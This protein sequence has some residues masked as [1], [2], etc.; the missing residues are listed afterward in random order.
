MTNTLQRRGEVDLGN[1]WENFCD[2]ITSTDNRIY[3]G[4][5]GVLM[6]P[7]ILSAATCFLI[8][9]LVAPPVDMEGIREP[10]IGALLDGNN[11]LTAAVIPTSAAIGLHFYPIWDAAS[12]DEW[13]YNG[14]P[15]QFIILHFLIGVWCYLGRLWELSYRLGMRP[16]ISVAFSA[17]AGAATAIF[18]IYP[19]G[20]GSFSEGMPLGISGTFHFMLGFQATHNILMNPLHMLGVTG[21]F[22]G[23]LLASLHGSLVTSSLVRETTLDE[24]INAG[25][26]FG[27]QET[28]YNL[29]AGHQ[30][31]LGRLLIP[32]LGVE[33]S[34]SLH[35][36]IV[37][38]P[39]VG[40]WCATLAI[41]VMAF[42]L[43]GFNFNQSILDSY[44]HP[45]PTDADILNRANL[46]LR[47]MH[48]P[49]THNFPIVLAGGPE[50]PVS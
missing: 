20:Q 31:Y 12:I 50:I 13:L 8:A 15:Y 35:F 48:S 14:G 19:I 46:G 24:S 9:F 43:N 29:L 33:N 42:N 38:V 49:N 3:I 25:Y 21:I 32:G 11:L 18:L 39:V 28:T 23:A 2:W 7:T 34:R 40:V 16:W 17:P 45:I 26:K 5:F 41:G 44:G 22:G 47:A 36:L 30:G 6:I 37:A 10:V 4:W 27:Q 1:Q